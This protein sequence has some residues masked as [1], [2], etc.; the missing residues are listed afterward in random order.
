MKTKNTN[1]E[2]RLKTHL[3]EDRERFPLP[4]GHFDSLKA[5]IL[6]NKDSEITK[7]SPK[8]GMRVVWT[9]VV[10]IAAAAALALFVMN[11][12]TVPA[13]IEEEPVLLSEAAEDF[14]EK[15]T[16][17]TVMVEMDTQTIMAIAAEPEY[18][19]LKE[20]VLFEEYLEETLYETEEADLFAEL[21]AEEIEDYLVENININSEL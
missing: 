9:V 20:E 10:P 2:D 8:R 19:T 18:Q 1:W 15:T 3:G 14:L 13:A 4:D 5:S 6:A 17:E 11:R 7:T 12:Q 21:E 16:E